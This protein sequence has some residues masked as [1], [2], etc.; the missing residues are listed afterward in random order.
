M[1]MA[2]VGARAGF[3]S[4]FPLLAGSALAN[5]AGSIVINGTAPVLR[6]GRS[7]R[8]AVSLSEVTNSR[9]VSLDAS[10]ILSFLQQSATRAVE[11]EA[12]VDRAD[13]AAPLRRREAD[14]LV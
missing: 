3:A 9:S 14:L 4:E 13:L 10:G 12:Q 2:W 11:A 5:P 1:A 6:N 7:L 8:L